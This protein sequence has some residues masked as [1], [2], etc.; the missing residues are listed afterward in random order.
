MSNI[1]Q[2]FNCTELPNCVKFRIISIDIYQDAWYPVVI[3]ATLK[4]LSQMSTVTIQVQFEKDQP[5]FPFFQI[6]EVVKDFD[7]VHETEETITIQYQVYEEDAGRVEAIFDAHSG[8]IIY[9]INGR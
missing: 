8:T 6:S 3:D 1:S 2:R 4:G 7:T 5:E 9:A